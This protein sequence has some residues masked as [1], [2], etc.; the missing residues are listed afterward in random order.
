[1][2]HKKWYNTVMFIIKK[3]SVKILIAVLV[4]A[5][6]T[7]TIGCM[8]MTGLESRAFVASDVPKVATYVQGEDGQLQRKGEMARGTE[9]T[10]TGQSATLEADAKAT[11]SADV[12]TE[13]DPTAGSDAT[14]E[15]DPTAGSDAT[16]EAA[17]TAGSDATKDA[18]AKSAIHLVLVKAGDLEAYISEDALVERVDQIVREEKV[19]ARTP[20]TVYQE[21]SGADIAGFARKGTVLDVVGFDEVNRDGV[22]KKYRVE[23]PDKDTGEALSG[24]VYGKYMVNTQE[25]AD[26]PYNENGENEKAKKARYGIELYGGRAENLDYYPVEKPEIKGNEFCKNARTMYLN[27]YAAVHNKEYLELIEESGCNAVVI[28][29]KDG[30]LSYDS[31]VAKELAPTAYKTSHVSMGEFKEAVKQF[32]DA[33]IYTIGRIACFNDG[34]YGKDNPED[35]I[36]GTGW[37]SAF[38][39]NA[40]EYNVKLAVEA[41][42]QMGFNEIQFDYVRFPEASYELSRSGADFRNEYGEE[43]AEA[44]QNFCFY[45]ADQIHEAGAYFSA[46]VF[47]ECS[48]GYPTAYGQYW[49]AISNVV[50]AISSMPYTDHFGDS[51]TWSE[52]KAVMKVWAN[53]AAKAQQMIP[54]PAV[55]RTWITGYNTPH[56]S[57]SVTYDEGKLRQQIDALNEAGLDGGFIPWNAASPIDKYR[58]YKGIWSGE[59]SSG[60][61]E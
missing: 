37:P 23:Y 1:M 35:C 12:T 4:L 51:D 30:P 39:R 10:V 58:Q 40:W 24:W 49:P 28:D 34:Y 15:A 14:T 18:D 52:P 27:W 33:G 45:A 17:P 53:N 26:A 21:N 25:K 42:R 19:Y 29:I 44:I 60:T 50:D 3:K 20:A 6:V 43:K 8:P 13:A 59:E 41:V 16:T 47:G 46:D 61:G 11:A 5:L 9:V 32:N 48:N 38:S 31:E 22:V 36:N 56:W 7:T 54:T 57:P 2:R 55:A